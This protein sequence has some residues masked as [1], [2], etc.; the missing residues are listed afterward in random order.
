MRTET[1]NV[2]R[3]DELSEEAK[4][5]ARAWYRNGDPWPWRAEWWESAQAFAKIAPI[6]IDRAD[7]DRRQV[8]FRWVGDGDVGKLAGVRAWRWLQNNG[9]F[10]LAEKKCPLTGYRGDADILS[11]INSARKSPQKIESLEQL[12]YECAQEW[13]F[14]AALDMEYAFSDEAVDGDINAGEY[15]FTA[16]G[17]FWE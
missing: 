10:D 11:P 13:V 4:G 7:F 1:M 5:V 14:H 2:Y 12:F 17:E 15:E 3:F 8:S 6:E 16:D 9:Y